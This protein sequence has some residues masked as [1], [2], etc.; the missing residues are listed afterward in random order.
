MI[1]SIHQPN[2]IPWVGFFNKILSSNVYV[3]FDDVQFPRGKDYA[4]RNQIKTNN[5]KKWL[6]VPVKGKSQ[7]RPWNEIEINNNGWVEQHLSLLE[8]FYKKSDYFT[9]YYPKLKDI[10]LKEHTKL[11]ELNLDLIKYILKS[12]NSDTDI[13]ISSDIKTEKQGME[14]I[15]H[16]LKELN[17]T[18]YISGSGDGSKR[19]IEEK[20]FEENNIKLIWQNY[21]QLEYK[22]QH[23]EFIPYMTI[24][25]LLFNHGPN[26]KR[27]IL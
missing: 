13:I 11:I 21:T 17:T 15:L 18:T 23:G 3:V 16:I 1:V 25:D 12:L 22:Q 7:L 27:Y 2:Y 14:K 19:Y 10:Y 4:N 9:E 20:L 8:S 6:T 24:L 26:S 5:G